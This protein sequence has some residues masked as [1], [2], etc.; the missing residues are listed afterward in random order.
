MSIKVSA[1]RTCIGAGHNTGTARLW[2]D[3]KSVDTGAGRDAG[4]RFDATIGGTTSDY[5]LRSGSALSTTAGS[6]Q[7]SA[8]VFVNIAAPCPVRPFTS[9]GTWSITLP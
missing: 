1:R 2:Y 5:F 8:D 9:F 6:S 3:G 7:K 4:S